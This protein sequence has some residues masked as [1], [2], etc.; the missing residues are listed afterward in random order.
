VKPPPYYPAFAPNGLWLFPELKS[1]LKGL[2][3]RDIENI[4]KHVMALKIINSKSSKNACNIGN[5]VGLLA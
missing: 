1:A 3:F 2:R 4:Q 5:I